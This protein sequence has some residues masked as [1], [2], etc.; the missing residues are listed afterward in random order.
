MG[1]SIHGW[2]GLAGVVVTIALA[3]PLA[4][5]NATAAI[6]K[7]RAGDAAGAVA[8][9]RKAA[10]AGDADAAFNLAQAFRLGKGVPLD[11][12]AAQGW[13]ERAARRGHVD[14]AAMLGMLL[15]QSGDRI[16]GIRWLKGAADAGE[17]RAM[18]L[19]GT[20]L[21]NGDGVAADPVQAYALVS[22]AAA[23]G[24]PPAKST[25]ADMDEVM[26]LAQ[27]EKG[28]ALAQAMV[29]KAG[30]VAREAAVPREV[31]A[32]EPEPARPIA[33]SPA[34]AAKPRPPVAPAEP[35]P[36][37]AK[38]EPPVAS[39]KPKPATDKPKPPVATA[40]LKPATAKP[41][42]ATMAVAKP[43]VPTA[44][45]AGGWRIQLGAFSQ[46]S[47]A[48]ALFARLSHGPLAGK[49]PTYVAAGA[50][51]RLQVGP[52]PSRAAAA[53]ACGSLGGQACFPV[54]GK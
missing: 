32:A 16:G 21:Y 43:S 35:K 22:R 18:L 25:L 53:A 13:Y 10:E 23:Q 26:P 27:R 34:A 41:R 2:I 36:A 17:P 11:L 4:A 12:A 52:Y 46:R 5:Q 38:P 20:A 31:A 9:W 37:A 44:A 33:T 45:G 3:A 7:W 47:G 42:P 51:V 54:A 8:I 1:K 29:A 19:Y 14:A 24:L 15:F 6:D 48:A 50:V 49:S 40:K 30:S 39:A 28:V